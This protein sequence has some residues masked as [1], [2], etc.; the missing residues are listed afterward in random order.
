MTRLPEDMVREFHQ[1]FGFHVEDSPA[2]P[3][4][5]IR[6]ERARLIG[7]EA[8]ELVGELLA[9]LPFEIYREVVDSF[10]AR[11]IPEN[12]G[13]SLEGIAGELA[14]LE[15][16]TAG[17]AVNCGIPLNAA[18]AVVHA[19][20]MAKLDPDGRPIYSEHGKALKP[21]RWQPP[22]IAAVLAAAT[23]PERVA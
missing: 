15:Y 21:A 19:A 12:Q 2:L 20:N 5:Q 4:D 8:G 3:P 22:N 16:V 23:S 10:A 1:R 7:E 6:A 11:A 18:V 14:D 9:G 17:A 13:P